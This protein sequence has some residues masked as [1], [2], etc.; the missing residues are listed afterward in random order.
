MTLGPA[1]LYLALALLAWAPSPAA[2]QRLQCDR[3]HGE[4]ELLRQQ[5]RSLPEAERLLAPADVLHASAHGDMPCTECH[6]GVNRYPH[7]PTAVTRA[8]ASCHAPADTAWQRGAHATVQDRDPVACVSCHGV[9]DVA[10]VETWRSEAGIPIANRPCV[11]CHEAHSMPRDGPHTG[12]VLCASCHGAHDVRPP[13]DAASLLHPLRQIE[14]CG[15]CHE[16]IAALWQEDVHFDTLRARTSADPHAAAETL[17]GCTAC[18]D[19]H[20]MVRT[21]GTAFTAQSVERCTACH[22]RKGKS[23]F[24]SYH[25]KATALGSKVAASCADCHGAHGIRP[26]TE[27][28]SRTHPDNLVATC[29]ECHTHARAAFVRYDTHPEPLNR[30]RNPWIFYAFVFMNSVLVMTL[31]VFGLHTLL[32]WIR[33]VLD[34]RRG[35]AHG[36]GAGHGKGDVA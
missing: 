2:A 15:G 4:L 24:G 26:S 11:G 21:G 27:T 9:H 17:P 12:T 31:I 19:G 23:F 3:C 29:G 30:A 22:E 8:C 36:P 16:T 28:A 10:T 35:I 18:H 7:A 25:G 20:G 13:V 6:T 1:R 5:V 32:W 14:T 34:R 33:I